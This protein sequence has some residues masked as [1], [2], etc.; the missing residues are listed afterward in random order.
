M[1]PQSNFSGAHIGYS[2]VAEILPDNSYTVYNYTNF[3][4]GPSYMDESPIVSF[5]LDT[6]PFN[7]YNDMSLKRGKILKETSYS[8]DD[9]PK[10]EVDYSYTSLT[11]GEPTNFIIGAN[12][13]Y[14][15]VC[16]N[17]AASVDVGCAYKL[18]YFEY[19][20]NSI[21]TKTFNND[22]LTYITENSAYSYNAHNLMN[23]EVKS[24]SVGDFDEIQTTY[25]SD[26][27]NPTPTP[28]SG[29]TLYQ[30]LMKNMLGAPLDIK[31]CK[32]DGSNHKQISGTSYKYQIQ[33]S[34]PPQVQLTLDSKFESTSQVSPPSNLSFGNDGE[35]V[36]PSLYNAYIIYDEYDDLGNL[37]E[38]HYM[39]DIHTTI[40]WGYNYLLPIAKIENTTF[41]FIKN[42]L[43]VS[44]ADLQT[45][46]ES[47]L[48][49]IF[50]TLRSTLPDLKIYSYTYIPL[51]GMSTATD[52][53][54]ITTYYEYDSF[55]R[56]NTVKDNDHNIVKKYD[57]HFIGQ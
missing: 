32:Y 25:L 11:G 19:E 31:K 38:F 52:P 45:K 28:P 29:S 57:Y 2:E 22:G 36:L 21:T 44:Y 8:S 23:R 48:M 27:M 12:A 56:L 41:D 47:D 51:A 17:S 7:K 1:V 33:N 43:G 50:T 40:L 10:K 3:D 13:N 5:Y 55:N 30:L 34:T 49:A 16:S 20:P 37:V 53:N 39:N 24:S 35:E 14:F 42:N 15:T 4:T 6:S 9:N 46:S 26:F 54:G 18:Y